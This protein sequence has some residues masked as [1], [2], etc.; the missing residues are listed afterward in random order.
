MLVNNPLSSAMSRPLPPSGNSN[1]SLGGRPQL[2]HILSRD[3][4]SLNYS[5]RKAG[6]QIATTASLPPGNQTKPTQDTTIGGIGV[7]NS[8][9]TSAS[10]IPRI[11]SDRIRNEAGNKPIGTSTN[12]H[13]SKRISGANT[14]ETRTNANTSSTI[15]TLRSTQALRE[16]QKARLESL[17]NK[18]RN[19]NQ[20]KELQSRKSSSTRANKKTA[21]SSSPV[22]DTLATHIYG[23]NRSGVS[24]SN[25][26]ATY[27]YSGST[28]RTN[29]PEV[30]ENQYHVP[31][32]QPEYQRSQSEGTGYQRKARNNNEQTTIGR[33]KALESLKRR[34]SLRNRSGSK[35][36]NTVNRRTSTNGTTK[37]LRNRL[38]STMNDIDDALSKTAPTKTTLPRTAPEGHGRE[39]DQVMSSSFT[40]RTKSISKATGQV[41]PASSG[42]VTSRMTSQRR[43]TAELRL[44]QLERELQNISLQEKKAKAKA[45]KEESTIS[46]KPRRSRSTNQ[47]DVFTSKRE[48]GSSKRSSKGSSSRSGTSSSSLSVFRN[49]QRKVDRTT[50][51]GSSGVLN[52]R[53]DYAYGEDGIDDNDAD[54]NEDRII[55][56]YDRHRS[57]P[58]KSRGSPGMSRHLTNGSTTTPR[59]SG[60]PRGLCGLQNLGNTCF[61]NS[62]L[63]CMSNTALLREFFLSNSYKND[64]NVRNKAAKGHLAKAFG[65]LLHRM[66]TDRPDNENSSSSYASPYGGSSSSY[67][68]KRSFSER[69]VQVKKVVSRYASR[70]IGYSQ[71]DAHEFLRYLVDGL[72][73][74][75]NKITNQPSYEEIK[76]IDNEAELE[77][78]NRWWRHYCARNDSSIKD[79]FCGQLRSQVTCTQCGHVSYSYD[80]FFDLS[81]PLRP[82]KNRDGE[83]GDTSAKGMTKSS[84]R[85]RLFKFGR[86]RQSSGSSL[87]SR[88]RGDGGRGRG[89]PRSVLDCIHEFAATE[90]IADQYKCIKCKEI[91]TVRREI[92]IVR[93]PKVLV[94]HIKRFGGMSLRKKLTDKL[95]IHEEIDIGG[96]CSTVRPE[97]ELK[98]TRYRLRGVSNHMGGMGGGHYTADCFNTDTQQWHRF[99]DSSVSNSSIDSISGTNAYLLFY[100]QI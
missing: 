11:Q 86:S 33:D 53:E 54:Q 6:R 95:Q 83:L 8:R 39:R 37:S 81:V 35:T 55:S 70:F 7:G 76:D 64:I 74:D 36:N 34:L 24:S 46:T 98:S 93:C 15:P 13:F 73:E 4:K 43:T 57:S 14:N 88:L 9:R 99:N 67:L 41:M 62:I 17:Q 22:R 1:L 25:Q 63:Q 66:W 3:K 31:P 84:S 40:N 96:V 23:Y 5:S 20:T 65:N 26:S 68:G 69:P 12:L 18:Q 30:S 10:K 2:D 51:T 89:Q 45:N 87:S 32:R 97:D 61:M 90:V 85:S 77:R 44:K 91:T 100:S 80:P 59:T 50:T 94:L 38:S 78:C 79:I 75:L 48:K 58:G 28:G 72:H 47:E 56:P 29:A 42:T 82:K 71:H 49:R 19:N 92:S 60:K 16:R 21:S 27:G 52:S